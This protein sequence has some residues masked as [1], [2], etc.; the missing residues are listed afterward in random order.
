MMKS[1]RGLSLLAMAAAGVLHLLAA[2]QHMTHMTVHGLALLGFGVL[3]LAWVVVAWRWWTRIT[4]LAGIALSV[5]LILLWAMLYAMPTS[6]GGHLATHVRQFDG[7][8]IATKLL[9]GVAGALLIAAYA[10]AGRSAADRQG[11]NASRRR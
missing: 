2:P 4:I 8:L 9:E 1:L 5:G 11:W 3:Q 6:F 7:M 10:R